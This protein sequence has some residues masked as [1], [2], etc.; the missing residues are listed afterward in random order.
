MNT[1]RDNLFAGLFIVP[2]VLQSHY[3]NNIKPLQVRFK[4][5]IKIMMS[6]G[7]QMLLYNGM[8]YN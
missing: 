3:P 4:H 7:A 6:M 1:R 5:F 2:I 8:S